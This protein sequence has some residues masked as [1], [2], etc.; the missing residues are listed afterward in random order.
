MVGFEKVRFGGSSV[1]NPLSWQLNLAVRLNFIEN[2]RNGVEIDFDPPL[3]SANLLDM[4]ECLISRLQHHILRRYYIPQHYISHGMHCI[5]PAREISDL[6][7]LYMA[8]RAVPVRT[9]PVRTL[10][11]HGSQRFT[12]FTF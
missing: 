2:G 4:W 8:V 10:P 5:L 7:K 12:F 3:K 6:A 11:V 9:V 1:E